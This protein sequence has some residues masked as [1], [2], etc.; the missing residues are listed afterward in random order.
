MK[1]TENSVVEKLQKLQSQHRAMRQH[2]HAA[3]CRV[4]AHDQNSPEERW[5]EWPPERWGTSPNLETHG[6]KL[7]LCLDANQG[8]CWLRWGWRTQTVPLAPVPLVQ[9]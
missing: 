5:D 3:V 6:I 1:V 8:L 4:L 7:T 9:S 2:V